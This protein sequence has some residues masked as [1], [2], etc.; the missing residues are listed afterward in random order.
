MAYLSFPFRP[1][2]V[3]KEWLRRSLGL[4][5]QDMIR[6]LGGVRRGY[7]I[8]F[9]PCHQGHRNS[10]RQNFSGMCRRPHVIRVTAA[11]AGT[12]NHRG[13]SMTLLAT[14]GPRLKVAQSSLNR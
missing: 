11:A 4:S 14:R 10:V 5:V 13:T 6:A 1:Q 3:Y 9:S 8:T 12:P 7:L 2:P